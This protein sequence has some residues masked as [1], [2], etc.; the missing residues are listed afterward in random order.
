M[1][2]PNVERVRGLNNNSNNNKEKTNDTTHRPKHPMVLSSLDIELSNPFRFQFCQQQLFRSPQLGSLFMKISYAR[3]AT[4][5][6]ILHVVGVSQQ[7]KC[8]RI[9][10]RIALVFPFGCFG[11]GSSS[12]VVGRAANGVL[13]MVI[14][15]IQQVVGRS[16][17]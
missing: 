17:W 5:Q 15:I 8:A 16:R 7:S 11:C 9:P 14:E 2:R 12:I 6:Y 1:S 13:M 10:N 4:C 3:L